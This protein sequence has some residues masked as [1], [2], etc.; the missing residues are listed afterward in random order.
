MRQGASLETIL[1]TEQDI[2]NTFERNSTYLA[3]KDFGA[4]MPL[5]KIIRRYNLSKSTV[6]RWA[7]VEHRK[8]PVYAKCARYLADVDLLPF[9]LNSEN[10]LP[11]VELEAYVF[12]SGHITRGYVPVISTGENARLHARAAETLNALG[13]TAAPASTPNEQIAAKDNASHLGRLMY[14]LGM[15]PAEHGK[16][17]INCIQ[18]SRTIRAATDIF[19]RGRNRHAKK[20]ITAYA[21]ATARCRLNL[22]RELMLFSLGSKRDS[23][24]LGRQ[25]ASL[26][27]IVTPEKVECRTPEQANENGEMRYR[28]MIYLSRCNREFFEAA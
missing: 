19:R 18:L 26:L 2:V 1:V 3:W 16:K 15:P 5:K 20:I 28:S 14:S 10:I 6:Y 9:R 17:S 12:W 8:I 7:Q 21:R 25:V 22:S 13:I 24:L 27:N 23:E 11:F 4:G